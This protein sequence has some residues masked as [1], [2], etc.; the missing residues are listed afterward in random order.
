MK[1]FIVVLSSFLI[2][3]TSCKTQE[4]SDVKGVYPF[5][6]I[7]IDSVVVEYKDPA[8]IFSLGQESNNNLKSYL[9]GIKSD[10][11][12]KGKRLHGAKTVCNLRLFTN[13]NNYFINIKTHNEK[14]VTASFFK[15]NEEDNFKYSM[16]R[17]Y[18]AEPLLD[19]FK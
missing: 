2:I 17:L 1:H 4:K 8:K 10:S 13:Q 18:N 3:T 14:G 11:L 5:K 7:T 19:L 15:D 16:G 6:G 9:N 12:I